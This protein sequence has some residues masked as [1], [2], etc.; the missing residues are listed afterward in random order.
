MDTWYIVLSTFLS[1]CFVGK[2]LFFRAFFVS[3][4]KS[5]RSSCHLN[6]SPGEIFAAVFHSLCLPLRRFMLKWDMPGVSGMEDVSWRSEF[7]CEKKIKS[8]KYLKDCWYQFLHIYW[9]Y[10]HPM[11]TVEFSVVIS[12]TK[13]RM[14]MGRFIGIWYWPSTNPGDSYPGCKLNWTHHIYMIVED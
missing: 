3:E 11:V 7:W 6:M 1:W 9:I 2:P 5:T 13:L 8:M 12:L 4:E 14:L 10:P